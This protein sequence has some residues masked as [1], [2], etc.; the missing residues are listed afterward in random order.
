[1]ARQMGRSSNVEY[2]DRQTARQTDRPWRETALL[3]F[4]FCNL[5]PSCG[6]RDEESRKENSDDVCIASQRASSVTSDSFFSIFHAT[7]PLTHRAAVYPH[8]TQ[9][10]HRQPA[11]RNQGEQG[12]A[13]MERLSLPSLGLFKR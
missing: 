1:V 5:L 4:F 9:Y 7:P 6:D 12:P 11:G 8:D 2:I 3:S 13:A 10:A